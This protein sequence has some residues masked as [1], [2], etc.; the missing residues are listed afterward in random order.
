MK[1][2]GKN[3]CK[4]LGMM[5]L[6]VFAIG[7]GGGGGGGSGGTTFTLDA[8]DPVDIPA[9]GCVLVAG[10]EVIPGGAV[11][12]YSVFD[13]NADDMDIGIVDDSFGCAPASGLAYTTGTG[14]VSASDVVP[15]TST[16]NL[17]I[18]CFNLVETCIPTVDSWTYS[19]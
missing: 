9:G 8:N 18:S 11:T 17:V 10:P 15:V 14:S 12:S 16:Y 7:C 13:S 19:D 1:N 4:N 3:L 6:L 2:L 5:G